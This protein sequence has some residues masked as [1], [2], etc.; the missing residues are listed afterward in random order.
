MSPALHGSP[1]YRRD[2]ADSAQIRALELP[3]VYN[4]VCIDYNQIK[5]II[6]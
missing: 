1:K 2:S 4:R 5:G 3:Q 6:K